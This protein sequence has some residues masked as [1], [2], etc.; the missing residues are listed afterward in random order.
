VI[1]DVRHDGLI[2]PASLQ[3]LEGMLSQDEPLD[4]SWHRGWMLAMPPSSP[5]ILD[6]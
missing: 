5:L 3:A 1:D 6:R 4:G 2:E